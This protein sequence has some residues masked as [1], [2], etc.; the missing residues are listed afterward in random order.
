MKMKTKH[1]VR[2]LSLLL[3]LCMAAGMVPVVF[4]ED[5]APAA[6]T[7]RD[8]D[9]AADGDLLWTVDFH[10]GET[11][12]EWNYDESLKNG[13][14]ITD[15]EA[16]SG[17]KLTFT[18][19]AAGVV[20]FY[21]GNIPMY[22]VKDRVYTLS[23]Y[24][25]NT[26]P[27][28]I[29]LASQFSCVY[30][31]KKK[32]N[33][34]VGIN[35]VKSAAFDRMML[36]LN[37]SNKDELPPVSR[38][39]DTANKNRQ[40]FKLL[41]DGVSMVM[42]FYALNE[43]GEY[44][45]IHTQQI[46]AL[47]PDA[48]CLSV[49]MYTWDGVAGNDEISMGDVKIVK[50]DQV[51]NPAAAWRAAYDQAKDGEVLSR[52]SFGDITANRTGFGKVRNYTYATANGRSLRLQLGADAVSGTGAAQAFGVYLPDTQAHRYGSYTFEFYVNSNKR[53]DFG[54]LGVYNDT[55]DYHNIGFSYFNTDATKMFMKDHGWTNVSDAALTAAP[56]RAALTVHQQ[57]QT[58][59]T[60]D[61]IACN[62]KVEVDSVNRIMHS[63]ILTDEGFVKTASIAWG[64]DSALGS[65]LYFYAWDKGTDA[66]IGNLVIRKGLTAEAEPAETA[67]KAEAVQVGAVKDGKVTLRFVGS[68]RQADFNRLGFE[69]SAAAGAETRTFG[70]KTRIGVRRLTETTLDSTLAAVTAE[71][72]NAL[73]LWGYTLT[74]V[75]ATG[76]VTFTVR[77][78]AI[79][80]DG[81]VRYGT[82]LIFTLENGILK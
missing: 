77:P 14:K 11:F 7:A 81:S 62:V 53:V 24:T 31:E 42:R 6:G 17:A 75:P 49:G 67:P 46:E 10:F 12:E 9:T 57:M 52:V 43:D 71:S 65:T 29:R 1:P 26:N 16:G 78:Y 19:K 59:K 5:T 47:K 73:Y 23:W 66:E 51:N 64:E 76:T 39:A 44:Q 28:N 15:T 80:E 60:G 56:Y 70:Y 40:Y 36:I 2:F 41:V 18:N 22:T 48:P 74:D 8:Y 72:L 35:S 55:D 27:E 58:P 45:L 21:G 54:V 37:G 68:G 3:V 4:A 61:G 63:Y 50:G 38:A 25:E 20:G 82:A 69:I 13:L 30:K 32:N 33:A 34:R 79:L